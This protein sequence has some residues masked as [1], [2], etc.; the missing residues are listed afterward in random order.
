MTD[1]TINESHPLLSEVIKAECD[2][3]E[4]QNNYFTMVNTAKKLASNEILAR[5][6]KH[7]ELCIEPVSQYFF[8]CLKRGKIEQI[9][10]AITLMDSVESRVTSQLLKQSM[11]HLTYRVSKAA[12]MC[13]VDTSNI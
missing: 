2:W 11:P 6:D 5:N 7:A 8:Y 4:S 1:S 13:Q 9:R 3:Q 10:E 12:F